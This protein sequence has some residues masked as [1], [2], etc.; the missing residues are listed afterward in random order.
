MKSH[1]FESAL[2]PSGWQSGV[3]V[4]TEQGVIVKTETDVQANDND[5]IH[6]VVIPAM[7]NAHSHVFQRAMAGLSEW[8]T[9]PTDS[10]WS[11]RELMYRLANEID[12]EQ[13]Y[14]VAKTCYQ[15]M[16]SAGYHAVCEFHYVHRD[17]SQHSDTLT[18]SKTVMQAAHDVGL[19][20]T[21]L[22]VLYAFAGVGDQP[23]TE[24]QHRFELS[25]SE[26]IALW[27][28]LDAVKFP[29]QRVGIC[30]HSIR[31]VNQSM[32]R[33]VLAGLPTGVPVHIHIAEQ[34][35]E[36]EQSLKHHQMRP[37]EWLFA[38]FDVDACWS[39]VHATHLNDREIQ[40][41]A[42]S[43]AVA[44]ICPLTEANLGDGVF[45]M[46]SYQSQKGV[47]AIG[48]DSHIEINP[49]EELKML[50]YSQRLVHQQRNVC[51]DETQPHVGTWM[52]LE[53][54]KGGAQS[55]GLPVFGFEI[56]QRFAAISLAPTQATIDTEKAATLLDAW[57]FSD[58]VNHRLID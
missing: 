4:V 50:E 5:S 23:L 43:R 24:A 39:L 9:H 18:M 20:L 10:F 56:N 8:K 21:M 13:L 55:S 30:F 15:E 36:I 42:Q 45:P 46:P 1:Y 33:E 52:W 12:A 40:L 2:M 54:V 58:H 37:V 34:Q 28:Q 57:L 6:G 49:A 32:M 7:P 38:H 17:K 19:S 35:G 48:S 53:A 27:Q 26:Y 22:P 3:R 16:K 11:W 29:E 14:Q 41:I 31:A 51:C 44:V 25:V 47:W